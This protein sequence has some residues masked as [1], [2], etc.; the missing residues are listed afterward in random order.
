MNAPVINRKDRDLGIRE[1][2]MDTN[3]PVVGDSGGSIEKRQC[4]SVR[5]SASEYLLS[6][7]HLFSLPCQ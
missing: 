5:Y 7:Y 6:L 2:L 4:K 1:G 3:P